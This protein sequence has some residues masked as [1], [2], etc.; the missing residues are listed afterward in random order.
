MI[1]LTVK[2]NVFDSP[3]QTP[4][5]GVTEIVADPLETPLNT[6]ISSFPELAN[7]ILGFVFV[8][9]NTVPAFPLKT[10]FL[11]K[12]PWHII[13]GFTAVTFGSSPI[14]I[15][16]FFVFGHVPCVL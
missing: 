8:H 16:I 1:G 9:S 15:E 13:W 5:N 14:E 10:I 4:T 6:W 7:P 2:L 3:L 11:K 12:S